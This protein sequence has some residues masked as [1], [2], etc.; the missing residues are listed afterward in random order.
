M[1][2]A[3]MPG[4]SDADERVAARAADAAPPRSAD[5]N[6]R[7]TR[8]PL[9]T[10]FVSLSGRCDPD[11]CGAAAARGGHDHL[12]ALVGV[13][14]RVR[15]IRPVGRHRAHRLAATRAP[16]VNGWPGRHVDQLHQT[17]CATTSC[18]PEIHSAN[19]CLEIPRTP[20]LSRAGAIFAVG[21]NIHMFGSSPP[22]V[23]MTKTPAANIVQAGGGP[24]TTK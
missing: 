7:A 12:P 21:G 18:S 15:H 2:A 17:G 14:H 10:G 1:N 22:A 20:I 13:A 9:C 11:F 16:G 19:L 23:G 4:L 24:P 3:V 6:R 8:Q 5:H